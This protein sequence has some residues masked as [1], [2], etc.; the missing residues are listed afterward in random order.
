MQIRV[1]Q[2]KEMVAAVVMI[3]KE[4]KVMQ[5]KRLQLELSWKMVPVSGSKMMI[6]K[7]R[8]FKRALSSF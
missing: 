8:D 1:E 5:L 6:S 2:I 7:Y 4:T 3:A